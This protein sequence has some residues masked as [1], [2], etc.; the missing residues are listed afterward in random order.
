MDVGIGML[1]YFLGEATPYAVVAGGGYLA[2]R[3]V[4]AYERRSVSPD[5]LDALADRVR[6]LEDVVDQVEDQIE[7]AEEV[8]RFTTRVLAGHVANTR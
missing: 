8:Q 2:W 5:R 1:S 3:F 6:I 7:R 4:R